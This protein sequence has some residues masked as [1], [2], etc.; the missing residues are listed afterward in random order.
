MMQH[1]LAL[2]T[3]RKNQTVTL[4][5]NGFAKEFYDFVGW[6]AKDNETGNWCHGEEGTEWASQSTIDALELEKH[7]FKDK[8]NFTVPAYKEGGSITLYAQWSPKPYYITY[9]GNGGVLTEEHKDTPLVDIPVGYDEQYT[10]LGDLYTKEKSDFAFW[11]VKKTEGAIT[12]YLGYDKNNVLGWYKTPA[13][14]YQMQ[15]NDKILEKIVLNDGTSNFTLGMVGE[16]FTLEAQ[17][18]THFTVNFLDSNGNPAFDA[19]NS[20]M[21][22]PGTYTD[23]GASN[24]AY[25]RGFTAS[26]EYLQDYSHYTSYYGKTQTKAT[27]RLWQSHY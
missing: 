14:L 6:Y 8:D 3:A 27:V 24:N 25:E 19:W 22:M 12:Y 26:T 15:P 17:W 4:L 10:A 16:H 1:S 7:L 13:V 5:E 21:F 11:A 20:Y 9:D 23:N 18:N 2:Q